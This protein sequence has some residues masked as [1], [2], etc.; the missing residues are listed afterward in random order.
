MITRRL[1][2]AAALCAAATSA[3]LAFAGERAAERVTARDP[4]VR[5]MPPHQ[6]NTGAFMRLRNGGDQ[7]HKLVAAA[8]PAAKVVELHEHVHDGGVMKMRPV[9]E[10]EIKAR[11]ET[12]L[13]PG[14]LHVMLIGL[15]K[16][17]KE[18]E[19]VPITL[20]FEDGSTVKIEAP[21][22]RP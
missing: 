7:G 14:G 21:V 11:G 18:G 1:I 6:P 5:L 22:R 16:P 10:I 19:A 20:T 13:E 15:V 12:V 17:L 8:S 4:F 2:L 3:A 9:K